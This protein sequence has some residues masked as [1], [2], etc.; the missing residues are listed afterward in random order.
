MVKGTVAIQK[1][2]YNWIRF[3]AETKSGQFLFYANPVTVGYK[4]K[5]QFITFGEIKAYDQ[6]NLI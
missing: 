2:T 6:R 1:E 4:K 3:G 5:H